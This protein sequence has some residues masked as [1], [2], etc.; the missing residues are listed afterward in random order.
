MR[1]VRSWRLGEAL[2]AGRG[3]AGSLLG[4]LGCALLAIT[5]Y[6]PS[7]ASS[8]QFDDW[9]VIVSDA[10]VHSLAAWAG[11][12]PGI[13]PLLKFTYALNHELGGSPWEFRAFNIAVHALNTLLVFALLYELSS[14]QGREPALARL[15][16][17]VATLLFALH[18]V[19]T[20]AVTYIS[21]R[22]TSLSAFFSL[23]S[24]LVWAKTLDGLRPL[25]GRLLSAVLFALALAVKETA[26]VLP[27]VLLLWYAVAR[28]IRPA[29]EDPPR[30]LLGHS[31][32]LQI[33]P[34]M[35]IAIAGLIVAS[36]WQP[37]RRLLEA[38]LLVRSVA[39]N[40]L[41]QADAIFWLVGQLLCLAPI[42]PDPVLGAQSGPDAATWLRATLVAAAIV[43]GFGQLRRRPALAFGTLWFFLWL[44]PTNSVL[45]RRDV[46]NDRQ[47]YLAMIGPAWL[48]A[49]ALVR[50][51]RSIDRPWERRRSIVLGVALTA[52][53][54]ITSALTMR[55]NRIY[56]DEV[57]FWEAV[58]QRSP[59]SARAADNLGFA[60]AMACRP[61]DAARQFGRALRLDPNNVRARVNARLLE[62]GALPTEMAQRDCPHPAPN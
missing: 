28:P 1:A 11:S 55:Q 39:S 31:A 41:A 61:Q 30:A 51:P 42:N 23:A 6:L 3:A 25:P 58:V 60:Y 8:F 26:I 33:A 48:A 34:Y 46:V 2:R 24:L 29:T 10:R 36:T 53:I 35:V 56:A 37:Y 43:A 21:G 19:Q 17:L 15:S 27:L 14:K 32:L 7:L 52:L 57:T 45:P 18:P 49:L 59:A 12:M 20:E 4:P 38:S 47:L 22:S 9:G 40:L 5:I 54:G 13:R 16:A 44:L 62:Q 50:I